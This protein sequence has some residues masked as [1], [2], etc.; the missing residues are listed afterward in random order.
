MRIVKPKD[1]EVDIVMSKAFMAMNSRTS[2]GEPVEKA[3]HQEVEK[4]LSKRQQGYVMGAFRDSVAHQ[5]AAYAE[6][7]RDAIQWMT[8]GGTAPFEEE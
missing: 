2:V 5:C 8:N 4:L 3:F 1:E 6:G 7:V